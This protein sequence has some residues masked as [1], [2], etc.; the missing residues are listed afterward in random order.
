[1]ADPLQASIAIAG[2]GLHAQ[3]QRM[4]VVSEN[5]ANANTTGATPGSDPY[6]R[7]T[8]SFVSVLD[9]EMGM[10]SVQVSRVGNDDGPFIELHDPNHMAADENG[11]VKLPNVNMLMEM[12]DM[13]EAIRSYEANLQVVRQARD[14]ISMTID[15]MRT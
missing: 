12:A 11:I 15:M 6:V 10:N 13:R 8:I 5:I 9:R 14:M 2:S 3:S 4:R 7:K 1:M